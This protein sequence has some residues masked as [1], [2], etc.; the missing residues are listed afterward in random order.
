M[1]RLALLTLVFGSG[2]AN[3]N[4]AETSQRREEI[5][6]TSTGNI[7]LS[8]SLTLPHGE[9]PFPAIVLLGGSERLGRAAI[10]NW[11]NA[12]AFVER[13]IAVFSFDSPGRGKSQGSRWGR[14]HQERADDAL[15][16]IRTIAKRPDI[17]ADSIGLYGG[18]EGGVVSF[19]AASQSES[20]AFAVTVSAPAV[21][22]ANVVD[23]KVTTLCLMLGLQGESFEK[24]VTFNRLIVALNLGNGR[25]DN[26]ELKETVEE[27]SDPNWH[28]LISLVE[29]QTKE[30]RTAT[31]EVF[32]ETA[33]KWESTDWFQSSKRLRELQ[34]PL[35]KMMGI[36]LS[37]LDVE[38][39]APVTARDLLEFD[40]AVLDKVRSSDSPNA[41]LLT[42][43]RS[44]E[45]DPVNFLEK[46]TCPIL[47][48]Y[49]EKD[50]DMS[51][52]PKIVQDV[53]SRTKHGDSTVRVFAGA[54]HQLEVTKGKHIA[55]H[56]LRKYR[57][58]EVDP[59]IL[60]WVLERVQ[61]GG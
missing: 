25:L 23:D 26:D 39:S 44:R 38:L 50:H 22:F 16:A 11:T 34:A 61:A 59:L 47:C 36:D 32:V 57:H 56:E 28:R 13:G 40:A 20:V 45:E 55:P 51:T 53:F 1:I 31:Q 52:Y 19:R 24:V 6:F 7:V 60:N 30:N 42:S 49:G 46:I 41:M 29:E 14:T 18:S 15:A 10:Y 17:E 9:G 43:D 35:F 37:E 54:G 3:A 5:T 48:I 58:K 12:N 33:E 2:I 21:P 8:G 27:W 4:P